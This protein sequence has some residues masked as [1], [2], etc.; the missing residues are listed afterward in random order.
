MLSDTQKTRLKT[1]LYALDTP[2][3]ARD[4][5]AI[6]PPP[7]EARRGP[8]PMGESFYRCKHCL[9]FYETTFEKCKWCGYQT[10]MPDQERG[11]EPKVYPDRESARTVQLAEY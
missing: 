8:C 6:N 7:G 11:G 4:V 9:G 2:E 1:G 10:P 3:S 5:L